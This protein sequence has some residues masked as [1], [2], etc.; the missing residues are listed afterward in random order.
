MMEEGCCSVCQDE[1][2]LLVFTVGGVRMAV[3]TAQVDGMSHPEDV[4]MQGQ[5]ARGFHQIIPFRDTVN[6]KA[7]WVLRVKDDAL[8]Y[9]VII[10]QPEEIVPVN[11]EALQPL[12]PLIGAGGGAEAIWG[13]MV[14][15]DGT[16][17]LLVDLYKLPKCFSS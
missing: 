9:G 7:P 13:G 5:V 14:R 4:E 8:P 6:Y 12:P 16:I 10:D 1:L 11:L 15:A 3:D 17:I 2:T